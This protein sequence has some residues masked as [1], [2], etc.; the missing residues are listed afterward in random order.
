MLRIFACLISVISIVCPNSSFALCSNFT[1]ST[2]DVGGAA[3]AQWRTDYPVSAPNDPVPWESIDFRSDAVAYMNAVLSTAKGQFRRDNRKLVGTGMEKWWISLWLD[4]TT[5]GREPYMGLTKE[6]GPDPGDLSESNSPGSQVWAVGFYNAKGASIF[7]DVFAEP[8]APVVPVSVNFPE[9]TASV[10]FLFTDAS[11]DE[12]SYLA[13]A[14][15]YD[16]NIDAAGSGSTGRP[17]T[18]RSKRTVR[19]LQVDVSVKHNLSSTTGWVF[20]TF[21]WV[22][23]ARGDGLFDNLVPVS[24]QWGDDPGIYDNAISQSWINPSLRGVMY[25]W[26]KRPTLG[27]N[28]RA[29]GP[30]DNIRS[31]CLSCHAAA[32]TPRSSHGILGNRFDMRDIGDLKTVQ[33]HV[34]LWFGNLKSGDLF[35]AKKPAVAALDYSLQLEAALFRL[36]LACRD[37]ALNGST[38]AVCR[39]SG[40]YNRPACAASMTTVRLPSDE[41]RLEEESPPRQ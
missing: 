25:G 17:V 35:D 16:A 7:H 37:G 24:L 23:P 27:F 9:G 5:N 13:G 15:E 38:P 29:N 6:R 40:F 31:S 14:P 41:M 26:Q 19:L 28:G 1:G 10:K 22:G 18:G 32:R 30:A 39:A 8:C 4:Y 34:D 2:M 33:P 21:G 11:P 12:V 20:G 3:K 36:C